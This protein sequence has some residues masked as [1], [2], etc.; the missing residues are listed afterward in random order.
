MFP[1]WKSAGSTRRAC[2]ALRLTLYSSVVIMI[3][4]RLRSLFRSRGVAAPAPTHY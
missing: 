4:G 2:A 1:R 3:F